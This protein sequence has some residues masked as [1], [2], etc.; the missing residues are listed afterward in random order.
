MAACADY[1]SLEVLKSL[2]HMHIFRAFASLLFVIFSFT[3]HAQIDYHDYGIDTTY[4]VPTGLNIGDK[5]PMFEAKGADGQWVN[6]TEILA[7]HDIILIFYRGEWCPHCDW[8][9]SR[10]NDSLKYLEEHHVK[11]IAVAPENH[12]NV[13]KTVEKTGAEFIV[14]SDHTEYI[15]TNYDVLFHVS[16]KYVDKVKRKK[17]KD[18]AEAHGQDVA[19]LPVPATYV[20]KQD[21]TISYKHF[22]YDYAERPWVSELV[23]HIS[24]D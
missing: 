19:K 11:V 14:L 3:T 20:I 22:D 1:L 15:M 5:A 10:L 17:N 8:Y 18:L 23:T 9:L 7:D 12:S 24:A 4:D 16:E 21:G 6:S 13:Q 2:M